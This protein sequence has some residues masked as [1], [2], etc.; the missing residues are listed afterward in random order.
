[1]NVQ[2]VAIS[3]LA[4]TV[5]HCTE[6]GSAHM[7]VLAKENTCQG[8]Q[9]LPS[10]Q[11]GHCLIRHQRCQ[12][13]QSGCRELNHLCAAA[14]SFQQRQQ[15]CPPPSTT[16][17]TPLA[18]LHVHVHV[19]VCVCAFVHACVRAGMCISVCVSVRMSVCGCVSH[20]HV[21]SALNAG[22][23]NKGGMSKSLV[24]LFGAAMGG[25]CVEERCL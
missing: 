20:A 7:M 14:V 10:V 3:T 22:R 8:L 17:Q 12:L 6:E 9:P 2:E 11:T 13:R 24:C 25:W 1:M 5:S 4:A 16:G 21:V 18:F 19:C 23:S 15:L